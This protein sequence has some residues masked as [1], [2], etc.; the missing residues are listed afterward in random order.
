[1]NYC[2]DRISKVDFASLY[3]QRLGGFLKLRQLFIAA[4][5]IAAST[6]AMAASQ[7]IDLSSGSASF[8]STAPVLS[9]D[10]D[11]LEFS[12]LTSG[13]KY[14]FEFVLVGFDITGLKGSLAGEKLSV[15]SPSPKVNFAFAE[16]MVNGSNAFDLALRG[17]AGP[18]GRYF[19]EVTVTAVPEPA[20]V[21]LMF[22]GLGVVGF[23]A[24]RRKA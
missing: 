10:D 20:S 5:F 23:L 3:I 6:A 2:H 22:A 24:R 11:V 19:G 16:G 7:T 4:S 9:G 14:S 17:T 18:A 13:Q 15:L 12:G 21:A 8:S 1:V